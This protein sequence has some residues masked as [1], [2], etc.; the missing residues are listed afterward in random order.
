MIRPTYSN[1][2]TK[3][4]CYFYG[5]VFKIEANAHPNNMDLFLRCHE[6]NRRLY[7]I[8]KECNE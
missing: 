4:L 8:I 2:S 3:R 7:E 5:K 1:I 6:L